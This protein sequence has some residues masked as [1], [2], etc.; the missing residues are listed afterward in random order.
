MCVLIVLLVL[1][2]QA[3]IAETVAPDGAP[4]GG[5]PLILGVRSATDCPSVM[6]CSLHSQ[7]VPC[8]AILIRLNA[9][10][11]GRDGNLYQVQ[12]E[13][14]AFF[15]ALG[16]APPCTAT[17]T[18]PAVLNAAVQ[19]LSPFSPTYRPNCSAWASPPTP[20]SSPSSDVA[21]TVKSCQR[22][23]AECALLSSPCRRC[24]T[25][26]YDPT[27][28]AADTLLSADCLNMSVAIKIRLFFG[29][30]LGVAC[31]GLPACT[32]TKLLC[33]R[34]PQCL[35]CWRALAHGDARGAVRGCRSGEAGALI[36][37]IVGG[38]T[39]EAPVGCDY[40]REVCLNTTGCAGC[41]GAMGG[42]TDT[43]AIIAGSITPACAAVNDDPDGHPY[44]VMR[45]LFTTCPESIISSCARQ[46]WNCVTADPQCRQC[47]SNTAPPALATSCAQITAPIIKADCAACS[48]KVFRI[49]RIVYATSVVGGVSA[50]ACI[51]TITLL[52][53]HGRD[54]VSMRDR[55][56]VG[57]MAS[58]S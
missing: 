46:T 44:L 27:A 34:D 58:V 9:A 45:V 51:A 23:E 48:A 6:A 49:N 21:V 54:L 15:H 4:S 25:Q 37:Q 40:W 38:C 5:P 32:F 8:L 19:E 12:R 35:G 7:C 24:L 3:G 55:I 2:L 14:I 47:L 36:D 56:V 42:G 17:T 30:G 13:Q 50:I 41:L 57:L 43:A 29:D 20:P 53:A 11:T 16:A 33:A 1:V 10:E 31:F 52:V 18:P 28:R 39:Q 26:L 22:T